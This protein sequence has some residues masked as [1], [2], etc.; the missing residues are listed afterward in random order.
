MIG[1]LDDLDAQLAALSHALHGAREAAWRSPN[2]ERL[3]QM[4]VLEERMD[5]LLDK[6]LRLMANREK[7][8]A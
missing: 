7:Q 5:Y 4:Q 8:P 6:R 1:D 3:H 2:G